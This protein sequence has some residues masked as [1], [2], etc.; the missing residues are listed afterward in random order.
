MKLLFIALLTVILSASAIAQTSAERE[1]LKLYK[2]YEDAISRRDAT[3]HER[4]FAPDY[5]YTPGNGNFMDRTEHIKFT[6]SGS[7]VVESL[8]GENVRV[9]IYGK[10]AVVTGLWISVDKR[11]GN[12]FAERRIRFILVFVKRNGSRQIV[13][14]QRTG[15][16]R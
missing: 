12:K 8:R 4:L 16:V 7:V 5:T 9:R 15:V 3:V 14:E 11:L 13:A 10:T 1:V 6:K 2:E